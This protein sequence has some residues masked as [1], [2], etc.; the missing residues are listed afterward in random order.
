MAKTTLVRKQ[1]QPIKKVAEGMYFVKSTTHRQ[2]WY[3][4]RINIDTNEVH[5]P[6]N[7]WKYGHGQ[8]CRHMLQVLRLEGG[9]SV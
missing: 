2:L 6:C 1:E 5:C 9:I 3:T 7:G 4:V 8:I